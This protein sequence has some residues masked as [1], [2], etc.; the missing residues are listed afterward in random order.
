MDTAWIRSAYRCIIPL[1]DMGKVGTW[2]TGAVQDNSE[3]VR[4]EW[5]DLTVE[6]RGS[7]HQRD[8]SKRSYMTD[9]WHVAQAQQ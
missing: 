3:E 6:S 2:R 1:N 4:T 7:A 8:G 5:E 9:A